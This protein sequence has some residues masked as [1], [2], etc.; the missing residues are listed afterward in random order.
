[1]VG[2]DIYPETKQYFSELKHG[3]EIADVYSSAKFRL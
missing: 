2:T 1:M 3:Q